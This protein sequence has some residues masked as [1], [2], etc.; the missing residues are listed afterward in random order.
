M[1]APSYEIAH[2]RD[3]LQVPGDRR[4]ACLK[5]FRE[6]LSLAEAVKNTADVLTEIIGGDK[7]KNSVESFTWI[8]DGI[9]GF[10]GATIVLQED[11][12]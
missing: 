7:G 2:V 1:S 12:K 5:D 6:F 11:T 10:A 3:F 9:E 8:D 4:D